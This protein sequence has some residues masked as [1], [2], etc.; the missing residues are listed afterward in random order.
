MTKTLWALALT[1]TLVALTACTSS[2]FSTGTDP[3]KDCHDCG[4]ASCWSNPEMP[5]CPKSKGEPVEA[6][7]DEAAPACGITKVNTT[8]ELLYATTDAGATESTTSVDIRID[9]TI[10]GTKVAADFSETMLPTCDRCTVLTN[11]A[12]AIVIRVETSPSW[13]ELFL[14][15]TVTL[16]FGCPSYRGAIVFRVWQEKERRGQRFVTVVADLT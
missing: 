16:P 10:E 13:D 12:G 11:E 2:P 15:S 9:Y 3:E 6:S 1:T 4:P 7:T 8:G 14:P 5:G